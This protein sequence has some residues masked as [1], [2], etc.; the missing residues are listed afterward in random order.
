MLGERQLFS[1]GKFAARLRNWP[2]KFARGFDPFGDDDFGIR[3]GLGVALAIGHATGQFGNLN[4]KTV[5]V[6]APVNDQFVAG[7]HSMLILYFKSSSGTVLLG[8]LGLCVALLNIDNLYHA[9][10]WSKFDGSLCLSDLKPA[11]SKM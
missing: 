11:R 6:F 4:N 2:A 5:I 1:V 8:R 7:R 9:F 3:H 10:F